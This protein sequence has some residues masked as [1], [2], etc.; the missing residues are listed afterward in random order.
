MYLQNVYVSGSVKHQEVAYTLMAAQATLQGKGAFR[1]HGGGFAGT[2]QA[3]VPSDILDGFVAQME[4]AVGKGCCH[5][6]SIR[7]AGGIELE[8]E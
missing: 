8:K 3:F 6:L 1:V 5:V 7:Q 2:I 4:H